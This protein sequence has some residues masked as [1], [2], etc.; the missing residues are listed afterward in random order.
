[1]SSHKLVFDFCKLLSRERTWRKVN[2]MDCSYLDLKYRNRLFDDS[3]NTNEA[4]VYGYADRLLPLIDEISG[5]KDIP[6]ILD[7]GCGCG[8]ESLLMSLMKAQVVG[9]D[10]VEARTG[11]ANSR[12]KYYNLSSSVIPDVKFITANILN[13]LNMP[14]SFHIVWAIEAI[15]HIHPAEEF[16]KKAYDSLPDGCL[17]II[18]ESNAL[19]PIS[20]YRACKI[21]G[22]SSWYVHKIFKQID[23]KEHDKVAEERIFTIFQVREKLMEAGF[24]IKN[25]HMSGFIGSNILPD[26]LLKNKLITDSMIF[27]NGVMQKMPILKYLGANYTI[28]AVKKGKYKWSKD[29][30]R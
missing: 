10:L 11:Y 29:V 15:S 22:S 20:W 8:S 13:Y 12:L 19:N 3:G 9:V 2:G 23:D 6:K 25:I 18:A 5:F 1:M 24:I 17:F 7:V 4:Q 27:I 21:R 14:R 30:K 16:F 26:K 28:V